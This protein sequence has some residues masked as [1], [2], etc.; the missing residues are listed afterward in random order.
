MIIKTIAKKIQIKTK[1]K[2]N[3]T[4][5]IVFLINK[6]TLNWWTLFYSLKAILVLV[7]KLL[8]MTFIIL[9]FQVEKWLIK[10]SLKKQIFTSNISIWMSIQSKH[11]MKILYQKSAKLVVRKLYSHLPHNLKHN[12]NNN[13]YLRVNYNNL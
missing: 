2:I 3:L 1:T 10:M 6:Q 13:N 12:N 11:T 5:I 8:C 4:I 9:N 7:L